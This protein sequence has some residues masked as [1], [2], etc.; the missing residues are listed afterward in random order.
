MNMRAPWIVAASI[1]GALLAA[2]CSAPVSTDAI[3][4]GSA[5]RCATCHLPEFQGARRHH[6]GKPPA[7]TAC[8]LETSWQPAKVRHEWYPLDGAHENTECLKCHVGDPAV[9]TDLPSACVDCH[10]KD[11]DHAKNHEDRPTTCDDCHTTTKW[12]GAKDNGKKKKK[13]D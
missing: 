7:C 12:K 10:R 6:V 3:P 5:G 13:S 9:Y 8:H 11:Y 2:A 4:Q 1:A